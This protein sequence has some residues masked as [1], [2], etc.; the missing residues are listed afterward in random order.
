MRL[1]TRKAEHS[2]VITITDVA[3]RIPKLL[4]KLPHV[5][6]GLILANDTSPTKPMGFGCEFE[7]AARENPYGIALYYR[8]VQYTYT[9]F[10]EWANKIA[11]YLLS[12]GIKKGDVVTL[13]IENRPELLV[14][15]LACAKVGAIAALVN[16]SQTG[17]GLIHSINLVKPKMLLMMSKTN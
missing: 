6:H 16:C 10:N 11:H 12:C 13:L 15:S 14:T 8:D 17:K 9:Q 5:V 3:E 2:D 4:K 7:R 1:F